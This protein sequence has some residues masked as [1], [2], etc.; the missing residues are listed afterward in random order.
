MK[1]SNFRKI[2]Q[3]TKSNNEKIYIYYIIIMFVPLKEKIAR[4]L[5][6]H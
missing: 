5:Y 3:M 6:L 1:K 4:P 2:F